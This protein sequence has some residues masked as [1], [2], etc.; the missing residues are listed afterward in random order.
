M[1]LVP[2]PFADSLGGK[3]AEFVPASGCRRPAVGRAFSACCVALLSLLV[4]CGESSGK[5]TNVLLVTFD[6]TRADRLGCYGHAGASTPVVDALAAGGV[7]AERCQTTATVTLPAHGSLLTGLYPFRHGARNN[8]THR[9]LDDVDTLAELLAPEG[10]RTGAVVSALVLD[11]RFGLG[12]GFDVYD[13]D[14]SGG[15][16]RTFEYQ[17]TTADNTVDRAL[18]FLQQQG[19]DPFFLW[20]HFYDPHRPF[21]PPEP[22][23]SRFRGAPHDGELAFTDYELGRLLD[24][25]DGRGQRDDTLVVLS[26]DHGESFGEHGEKG[27]GLFVYESTC[28][29]PLIFQH[30]SLAAGQTL[31]EVTSVVD[32]VPTVLDLLGVRVPSGLH[33]ISLAPALRGEQPAPAGRMVYSEAMLPVLNYGWSDLRALTDDGGRYVR[34]PRAELYD[35]QT[36]ED[37]L[38]NLFDKSDPRARAFAS[39]LDSLLAEGERD[40]SQ[41]DLGQDDELR[42]GLAELGYV[43]AESQ[44]AAG[45]VLPDPKDRIVHFESLA[46]V[47]RLLVKERGDKAEVLLRQVLS[48][49]PGAAEPASLLVQALMRQ[50]RWEEAREL[51]SSLVQGP[52][53]LI[54]DFLNLSALERRAGLATWDKI[55]QLAISRWPWATTARHRRGLYLAEDGDNAGARSCFEAVLAIDEHDSAAKAALKGL[56]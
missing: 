40:G 41:G 30:E 37:E 36:D 15:E 20:V 46:E 1:P 19:A 27:H 48:A 45:E 50:K 29:V 42:R 8:G 7:L 12:Q 35:H 52:T 53:P 22:F 55:L 5:P 32:V 47:R 9:V 10:F 43:W 56:R 26:A 51:A 31:S 6:T 3:S 13:D 18:A 54:E 24:G 38:H 25:M 2:T 11:E 16:S 39:T 23:A 34:A 28:H 21:T 33:G 49:S 4:G 14:L 44:S 17:Q